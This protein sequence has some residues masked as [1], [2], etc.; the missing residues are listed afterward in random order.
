[1]SRACSAAGSASARRASR[2][3]ERSSARA[4]LL[5]T[6]LAWQSL[7]VVTCWRASARQAIRRLTSPVFTPS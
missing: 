4:A 1:M 2:A 6:W 3:K 7:T 5:A